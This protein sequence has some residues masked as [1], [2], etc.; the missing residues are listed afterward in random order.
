MLDDPCQRPEFVEEDGM[1]KSARRSSPPTVN[2]LHD[3]VVVLLAEG[4]A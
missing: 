4:G 1:R 3:V 2:H